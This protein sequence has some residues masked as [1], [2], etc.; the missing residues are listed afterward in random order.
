MNKITEHRHAAEEELLLAIL[1]AGKS[2]G[3]ATNA[4]K[5]LMEWKQIDESPFDFLKTYIEHDKL[6]DYLKMCRI[7]TYNRIEKSF[8]GAV[9]LDP[10]TCTLED[11]EAIHGIGAKT[12]RYFLMVTRHENKY[13]ALDV[14]ILRWLKYLGYDVPKSTPTTPARYTEVEQFFMNEAK[15]RKMEPRILDSKVWKFCS[16]GGYKTKEWAEELQKRGKITGALPPDR[17][18][19]V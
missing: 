19:D 11:L 14:H 12:A 17:R 8:K 13:A 5:K 9:E 15:A 4:F 3:Y 16:D 18:A 10:L 7:G 6:L 2:A 1:V